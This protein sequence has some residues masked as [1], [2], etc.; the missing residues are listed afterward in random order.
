[1]KKIILI[2]SV[3]LATFSCQA[4]KNPQSNEA[5]QKKADSLATE[6]AELKSVLGFVLE[7]GMNSSYEDVKKQI[8]Q[9]RLMMKNQLEGRP[10]KIDCDENIPPILADENKFQQIMINL[11]DNAAKYSDENSQVTITVQNSRSENA[12]D[13]SIAN[14]GA[15]IPEDYIDRIFDKFVRVENHLTRKEQGSGLGLYIVKN[16]VEK[17]GGRITVM[18]NPEVTVFTVSFSAADYENHISK[19]L[20]SGDSSVELLLPHP[21]LLPTGEGVKNND[22]GNSDAC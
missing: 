15:G 9:V 21:N 22:K 12:V 10:V 6:L 2:L 11:L 7:R 19:K 8:E 14:H 16:L 3:A 17:M 4:T 1:M 13:I 18:S 20:S 5:L